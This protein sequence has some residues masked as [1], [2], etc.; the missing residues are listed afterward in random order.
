MD[1]M[2]PSAHRGHSADHRRPRQRPR[3]RPRVSQGHSE[4]KIVSGGGRVSVCVSWLGA[5]GCTI[6]T[7]IELKKDL[8]PAGQPP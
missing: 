4:K 7:Q 1:P 8:P 6:C 5:W 3:R 2:D